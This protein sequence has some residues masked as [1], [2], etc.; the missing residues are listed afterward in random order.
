MLSKLSYI[1][2]VIKEVL[3]TLCSPRKT[4]LNFLR[5]L[6]KSPD[7]DMFACTWQWGTDKRS[8]T[9]KIH[10]T[11]LFYL[12]SNQ[13]TS[14]PNCRPR[15]CNFSKISQKF[16]TKGMIIHQSRKIFG[17]DV[18]QLADP[19]LQTESA[20]TRPKTRRNGRKDDQRFRRPLVAFFASKKTAR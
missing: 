19:A 10:Q 9:L 5:G 3:P 13:N 4:S 14:K 7:V 8:E 12:E 17:W 11:F 15:K 16:K 6:P 20:V 2:R 1:N 18:L